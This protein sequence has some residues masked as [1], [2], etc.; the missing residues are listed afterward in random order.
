MSKEKEH[1]QPAAGAPGTK[2]PESR[3]RH[4]FITRRSSTRSSRKVKVDDDARG[5][6]RE[7]AAAEATD[8][9]QEMQRDKTETP[10]T[11]TTPAAEP[12]SSKCAQNIMTPPPHTESPPPSPTHVGT[13][14]MKRTRSDFEDQ[15][16]GQVK[17]NDIK[18]EIKTAKFWL[19]RPEV[20]IGPQQKTK[21]TLSRHVYI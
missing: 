10:R 12:T 6:E 5:L 9:A 20:Q 14:R 21:G 16:Y 13:E 2:D 17:S 15:L 1:A 8:A 18:M 19:S 4:I 7:A 3:Q 11:R